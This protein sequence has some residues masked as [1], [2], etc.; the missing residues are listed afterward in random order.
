MPDADRIEEIFEGFGA[1]SMID[2]ALIA[3]GIFGLLRVLSGTRAMTQVR[4]AVA[5]VLVAV[6]LG[7]VFDL[8]AVNYLVDNSAGLAVIAAVVVFQPEL[9]RALD[10][11][12][13]ASLGYRPDESHIA[14]TIRAV[15]EAVNQMASSRHGGL[16]VVERET[17]L[18]DIIDSGIPVDA[19]VSAELLKSIFFPNSP[20]HDMAVVIRDDRVIAAGCVLPL[21]DMITM[22]G[23][24]LGTR[25]RAGV[26][27]TET[28]DA[29]SVVVSEE[30]GEISVALAGRLT[31]VA[32]A[33][34]LSTV[35][36]WLLNPVQQ[37]QSIA[38]ARSPS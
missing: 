13:R 30:T 28:T 12:G 38:V 20:L 10:R 21:S 24:T 2:I 9:R 6:V 37:R 29:V 33:T 31:P 27:V 8:T 3:I 36:H 7:R 23:S 17:G 34:R 18:Q 11:M 26:G 14:I 15:S 1:S 25:H 19:R 5:I 32:D 35:L 16:V 22:S 4:G